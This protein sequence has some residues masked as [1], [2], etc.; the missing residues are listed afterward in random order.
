MVK[1][2]RADKELTNLVADV[3]IKNGGTA[4]G[5]G[6]MWH[7]VKDRLENLEQWEGR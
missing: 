7:Y 3:V 4:E 2:D 6:R 1:I 5:F